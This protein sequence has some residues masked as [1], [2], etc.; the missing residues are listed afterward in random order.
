MREENKTWIKV[1]MKAI[2]S[3]LLTFC[4]GF[5]V[6]WILWECSNKGIA[7]RG[8]DYY[9]AAFWGDRICL[10]IFIG[11]AVAYI[12]SNQ[13]L[14]KK[15]NLICIIIGLDGALI[16]IAI[17]ASWLISDDTI[18][19][20]TIP[21]LHYFNFAG[22]YHALFFV[23]MFGVIGY[24]LSRIWLFRKKMLSTQITIQEDVFLAMTI[25]AMSS[26][27]FL[28]GIDNYIE[29]YT[30]MQIMLYAYLL[31]LLFWLMFCITSRKNT[32]NRD[33]FVILSG[34][35]F[36]FGIV[37]MT[38]NGRWNLD[39]ILLSLVGALF[40]IALVKPDCLQPNSGKLRAALIAIP[41]Y[42]MYY[43]L[44]EI[45][46]NN[47]FD[48]IVMIVMVI[49]VPVL[50][51]ICLKE[52]GNI[53]FI[54]RVFACIVPLYI[55]ITS[56]RERIYLINSE[57]NLAD[58]FM[59]F[60]IGRLSKGHITKQLFNQ[61]VDNE[62]KIDSSQEQDTKV[63][64]AVYF[65]IGTIVLADVIFVAMIIAWWTSATTNNLPL[66]M[67]LWDSS[68]MLLFILGCCVVVG[69]GTIIMLKK[70]SRILSP[71]CL[72]MGYCVCVLLIYSLRKPLYTDWRMVFLV[73]PIIA[74]S[75]M[76]SEGFYANTIGLK[77]LERERYDKILASIIGVGSIINLSAISWTSQKLTEEFS[78]PMI[79]FI[80][81]I[82]GIA[83][84]CIVLPVLTEQ[85]NYHKAKETKLIRSQAVVSVVQDGF[86]I[87]LLIIITG[88]IPLYFSSILGDDSKTIFTGIVMLISVLS[89]PLSYCLKNNQEHY[90]R[91]EEEYKRLYEQE[92]EDRPILD[93]QR[94]TL[95][96]HISTQNICTYLSA[97]PYLLPIDLLKLIMNRATGE[98]LLKDTSFI[99]AFIEP[100]KIIKYFE[101]NKQSK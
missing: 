14:G 82:L 79:Y 58:A 42:V 33:L 30:L 98:N 38:L 57:Q 5:G 52:Y 87:G 83:M 60:V 48:T 62:E 44:F 81:S 75:V 16:A 22:W 50:M 94:K 8:F 68:K 55:V 37:I 2:A 21:K 13:K 61:V 26:F 66:A 25:G 63:K 43:A 101:I 56:F 72:T 88:L 7:L 95:K 51:G 1:V 65:N 80:I 89:W 4:A 36:A 9:L 97:F 59:T 70:R 10:P 64:E 100:Q 78:N 32:W 96:K 47:L 41:M 93:I 92:K 67:P 86:T 34:V 54:A 23:A 15:D 77:G 40:T 45:M 17:Q 46:W 20:W 29:K 27:L 69:M 11:S 39:Y 28:N 71:I 31:L 18:L 73:F 84:V 6:M 85:I 99:Y 76:L 35:S 49:I 74:S 12:L 91:K 24:I 90:G 3:G 19:N 53:D